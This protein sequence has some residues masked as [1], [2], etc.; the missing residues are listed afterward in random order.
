MDLTG[1]EATLPVEFCLGWIC[2][3]LLATRSWSRSFSKMQTSSRKSSICA[4]CS[5]SS[6]RAFSAALSAAWR[7]V[8]RIAICLCACFRSSAAPLPPAS[9]RRVSSSA[10]SSSSRTCESSSASSSSSTRAVTFDSAFVSRSAKVG[11]SKQNH[12]IQNLLCTHRL[13]P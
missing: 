12:R 5:A 13:S 11:L 4:P 6:R 10:R 3:A 8:L 1:L 7:S 2:N 9:R